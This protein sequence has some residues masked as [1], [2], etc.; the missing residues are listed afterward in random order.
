[1][2]KARPGKKPLVSAAAS[3]RVPNWVWKYMSTTSRQPTTPPT[4]THT[5]RSCH[6]WWLECFVV[7][8]D[9]DLVQNEWKHFLQCSC[10]EYFMQTS[11]QKVKFDTWGVS[12]L[13]SG[14]LAMNILHEDT[15]RGM[16]DFDANTQHENVQLFNAIW[17]CPLHVVIY[18]DVRC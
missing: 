3:L 8:I 14:D 11:W 13:I 4:T 1:M 10:S 2:A 5:T 18:E 7:T 6:V 12:K 16:I 15:Q 17:Y 9:V